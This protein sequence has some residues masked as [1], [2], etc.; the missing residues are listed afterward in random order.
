MADTYNK[1]E[2]EK[3]KAQRR[4]EKA[5]KREAKKDTETAGDLD[6]MMAYVDENGVIRDTPPDPSNKKEIKAKNIELGVPKREKEEIDPILEGMINYFD[7]EKG[8]GFIK[9][10]EDENI[11]VHHSNITGDPVKGKKVK[12]EKEK[13][14]KGWVAVRV[15][16]Q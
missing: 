16:V 11:F 6:S 8:Y 10:S 3:K 15:T 13:G 12:F 7:D 4:K 14:P 1:K 2:R 9:Y 5:M